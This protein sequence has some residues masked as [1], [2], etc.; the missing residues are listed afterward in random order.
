MNGTSAS[1]PIRLVVNADD[2]G[3]FD[4]VSRGIIDAA[5]QGR[6]TATGVMAN[7]PALDQWLDRLKAL[8]SFSVGVHLN[9][10]LGRPLTVEMTHALAASDGAFPL[11]GALAASI[12]LGRLSAATVINEWRAQIQRCVQAGLQLEFLNSH[13]HVHMLPA[14][15]PGV[16]SLAREFNIPH[17]RAP[18]P[19]W[20]PVWN[21]AACI[22]N[23]VFVTVKML[24]PRPPRPEPVLIGVSQ[25]GQLDQA[26]CEWRF[27]RLRRG[28]SYELMCHPGWNDEVA[29]R[30][31]RLGAYHNWE[32]ELQTLTSA[33]FSG[34][35]RDNQ[36]SLA[37][38]ADLRP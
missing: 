30:D 34:F 28:C 36:I 2:F 33:E 10:T 29:L 18:Q 5:E 17:V 6:V 37:S 7:G 22:R 25:S 38:Y 13:E 9:A 27:S 16:L 12:L 31:P 32:G 4:Q 8:R 21:L 26:Y 19:E 20:G 14:L 24:V 11:K 15:Y 23:G 1:P 35:L 3:Y